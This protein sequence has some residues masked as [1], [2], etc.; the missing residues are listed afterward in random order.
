MHAQA[1][2]LA[3]ASLTVMS[4]FVL[5]RVLGLVRNVVV[6]QQ[7]GTGRDYEAFIAALTIP[8][9]VFQILAGGAVGSAF[10]PVFMGYFSRDDDE[11]AW[12][13]T[14]LVM[15]MALV[16]TIPVLI[17]LAI[18]A[19]P[20]AEVIVPGWDPAS[21]DLT[22]SLMRIMLVT[23]AMFAVS[24]F[25]TGVLN[26]FQR[27]ALAGLA[28][29]IYNLSIIVSALLFR[30]LGIE[31]V[32][33]GAAVGSL[34]HL[35]IQIP[36][37]IAVGMH[38][39]IGFDFRFRHAGVREVLRLMGPRMIGLGVTQINQLV[40]VILASYLIVG[41]LGYLNVAW[42]MLMTPLV[43]AMAV[44]TA[45]FPTLAEESA[46]NHPEAVRDVF[47][48]S[49]RTILFLTV[50]MA[51]GLITLGEPLIRLLFEHGAF[52][53]ESTRLTQYALTFYAIGL[54]GHAT[55]EIVDRVFYAVHDTWTPVKAASMSFGINLVLGL[56]LMWTPLNFG[57]LALAN[58]LAA[59]SEATLLMVMVRRRIPGLEMG[60]IVG[61]LSRTVAASLLMGLTVAMLPHVLQDRLPFATSVELPIVV[62]LVVLAGGMVYFVFSFL[63]QSEEL[64][65]LLRL[66]R[67]RG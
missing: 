3:A 22:A 62:A 48:L 64:R 49:L 58:S 23:P 63:L 50:P 15:T 55:V 18:F 66:A 19:R 51:V 5:S 31:G 59:L 46:S 10:I 38:F 33:I 65:V 45:V 61:T 26:S 1:R 40:N 8:D 28:P 27:F 43:L 35:L 6:A 16:I 30:S 11:G 60:Q 14:S 67:A 9:L 24:G 39:R 17:V 47:M 56:T 53:A 42:L 29:L 52:T 41:S 20:L 7:F 12:R 32:A 57:G 25:A 37:L 36:G 21:K 34:L 4:L 54:A 44:S 2:K 13:L